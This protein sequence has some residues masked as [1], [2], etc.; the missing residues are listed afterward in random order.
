MLVKA[1]EGAKETANLKAVTN[2]QMPDRDCVVEFRFH[3]ISTS[4][5][6]LVDDSY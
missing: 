6:A 2:S 3:F 4:S 5:S 1:S